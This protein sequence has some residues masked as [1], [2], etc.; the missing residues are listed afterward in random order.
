MHVLSVADIQLIVDLYE[1]QDVVR[2]PAG[3][4]RQIDRLI[5]MGYLRP[6]RGIFTLT[7]LGEKTA[8]S[9]QA[10][11]FV[12]SRSQDA[13]PAAAA[14]ANGEASTAEAVAEEVATVESEAA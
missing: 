10:R 4:E 3:R 11:R 6:M 5:H 14:L 1:T 2:D 9:L 12:P 7:E 13:R 8:H